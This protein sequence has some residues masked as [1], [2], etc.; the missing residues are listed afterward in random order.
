MGVDVTRD[1]A[2]VSICCGD[3]TAPWSSGMRQALEAGD[4][5]VNIGYALGFSGEATVTKVA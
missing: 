4:E 5:V 1:L 3:F 2:V